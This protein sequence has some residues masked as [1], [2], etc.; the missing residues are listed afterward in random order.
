MSFFK[1]KLTKAEVS[2]SYDD[3]LIKPAHSAV[4]PAN[5]DLTLKLNDKLNLAL[6]IFSAAMD[7]ITD[8]GMARAMTMYGC[9]GPL[10][11]NVVTD[12]NIE[13]IKKLKEEFGDNKP[14]CVSVGVNNSE[15]EMTKMVKAGANMIV[16][17]CAHAHSENVGNIVKW[18]STTFPEVYLIAGNVVTAEAAKFLVERGA[19]AIKVGI[20]CGSICT[21]RKVTG[22]GR[23]Q[24][25]AI[26]EVAD[27]CKERNVLVIADGGIRTTDEIVKAIAC[28]ADAVMLGNMLA[29]SDECPGDIVEIDGEKYKYYRGMG[30]Y[31]VMKENKNEGRYNRHL[32]ATCKWV[33]EGVESYVKAKGPVKDILHSIEWGV[34]AA[35]GYLGASNLKEA[36]ERSFFTK[37][38]ASVLSRN[39]YHSID[40]LIG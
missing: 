11:K 2:F 38:T 26:A 40:K 17:D 8:Y 28:G 21:T 24:I 39:N 25:S 34:K 12:G 5:I 13:N 7:T 33:A 27:Y 6:P 1:D 30:S 14:I 32:L 23:G 15:E 18:I 22:I 36:K 9:C 3:I 31:G 16:V 37:T 29:G 4:L 20:G 10:H 35:F 19:N